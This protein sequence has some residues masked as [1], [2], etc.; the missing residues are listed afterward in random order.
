MSSVARGSYLVLSHPASDIYGELIAES[1]RRYNE[2][3]VTPVTRP[4]ALTAAP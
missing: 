2:S 3:V 1:A 4:E